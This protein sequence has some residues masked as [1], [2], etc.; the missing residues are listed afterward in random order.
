MGGGL[1][2]E[3]EVVFEEAELL[4]A[5]AEFEGAGGEGVEAAEGGG[6]VG[7]QAEVLPYLRVSVVTVVGDE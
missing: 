1:D 4:Q 7:V 6:S 3:G 5:L 2:V